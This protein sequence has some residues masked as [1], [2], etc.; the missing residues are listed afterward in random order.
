MRPIFPVLVAICCL[1]GGCSLFTSANQNFVSGVEGYADVILPEYEAYLD[2]DGQE[3]KCPKCG[4][5]VPP[6][7]SKETVELRKDT[8]SKFKALIQEYKEKDD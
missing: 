2:R 1:L 7:L 5:V 8:S 4:N 6:K 3:V